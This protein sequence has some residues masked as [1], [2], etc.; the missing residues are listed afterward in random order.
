METFISN[1]SFI[2]IKHTYLYTTQSTLPAY[3]AC[4]QPSIN[5]AVKSG[6]A[7][8]RMRGTCP[9]PGRSTESKFDEKKFSD[10]RIEVKC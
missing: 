6:M 2:N 1:V 8:L 3:P 4:R 9:L 7:M 5:G 10:R